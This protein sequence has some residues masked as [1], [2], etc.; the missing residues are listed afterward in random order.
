MS[1]H[2]T[3]PIVL[4]GVSKSYDGQPVLQDIS[5]TFPFGSVTCISGPSGC[6]KTTL[7][8]LIAGLEKPDQGT[9]EDVPSL[10]AVF[11]E[12][13]LLPHLSARDNI[14]KLLPLKRRDAVKE[15]NFWLSELGL[16]EEANKL[17]AQL[18]GGMQQRVAIGRALA[19]CRARNCGLLILDEAFK[20]LDPTRKAS[21]IELIKK[22]TKG[23]TVI[24]VSHEVEEY[25]DWAERYV[26]L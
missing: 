20:G 23:I 15:A 18:S 26:K 5:L 16:S 22:H 13:R 9:V 14:A 12:P 25:A 2:R 21:V 3:T 19:F 4:S 24:A 7:L 8:R 17:P 6:G 1:E 11:Q 10:S